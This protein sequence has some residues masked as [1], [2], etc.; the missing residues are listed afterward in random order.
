[1]TY[2]HEFI[3]FIEFTIQINKSN[4]MIVDIE[5]IVYDKE[6]NCLNKFYFNKFNV[7]FSNMQIFATSSCYISYTARKDANDSNEVVK[8][9]VLF[10]NK[11][12][13][14]MVLGAYK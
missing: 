2:L 8:A 14:F 1:M 3:K 12:H 7:R 4:S 6:Y 9:S 11:L 5:H 13:F 10:F